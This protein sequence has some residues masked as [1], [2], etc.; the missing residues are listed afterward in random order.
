LRTH[1][2]SDHSKR[3][4]RAIKSARGNTKADISHGGG[5][6]LTDD[7]HGLDR[8][9]GR[10][11]ARE[12]GM[13]RAAVISVVSALVTVMMESS[14]TTMV[15]GVVVMD[16]RS[17]CGRDTLRADQRRRHEARKLG[18]HKQR[19]QQTDKAGYRPKP[20]HQCCRRDYI[21]MN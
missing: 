4:W 21:R 12:K 19:D 20:F 15:I 5:Q 16:V 10:E 11:Y 8:N 18:H 3:S 1:F 6:P 17:D 9:H 14:L 7:I 13:Q 2:D